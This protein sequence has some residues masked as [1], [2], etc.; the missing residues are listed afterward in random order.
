MIQYD[1][2]DGDMNTMLYHHVYV[3]HVDIYHTSYS[4]QGSTPQCSKRYRRRTIR[5]AHHDI[6]PTLTKKM[7]PTYIIVSPF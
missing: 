4:G 6:R 2:F 3:H 1:S 5:N 7:H